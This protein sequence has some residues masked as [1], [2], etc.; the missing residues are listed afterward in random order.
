MAEEQVDAIYSSPLTRAMQTAE[1]L[2]RLTG[3][4]VTV[5]PG[6]AEW[7]QRSN[8][9]IPVEE[10]K[11]SND[12]RWQEMLDGG[13]NSEEDM[14]EFHSRVIDSIESVINDNPGQKV[15]IGRAHV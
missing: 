14:S 13:W 2:C 4:S 10:L 7:D 5:V 3:L 12:P 1:P 11:A 15:E 6:V 8:E 9:Y